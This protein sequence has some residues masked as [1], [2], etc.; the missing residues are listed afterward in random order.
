MRSE[1]YFEEEEGLNQAMEAFLG[2]ETSKDIDGLSGR[3][4][5]HDAGGA[6]RGVSLLA[7]GVLWI[8]SRRQQ[9]DYSGT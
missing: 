3:V 6:R 8:P 1:L 2:W 5:V 9:G 7:G 4:L